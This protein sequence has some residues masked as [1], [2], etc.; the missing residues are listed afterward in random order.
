MLL[1]EIVR[2]R[3]GEEAKNMDNESEEGTGELSARVRERE[4][5]ARVQE[6]EKEV[7]A[8]IKRR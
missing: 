6:R 8:T 4:V 5:S 1:C 3:G 2:E 7:S